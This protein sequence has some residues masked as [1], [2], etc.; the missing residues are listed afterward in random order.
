MIQEQLSKIYKTTINGKFR[1]DTGRYKYFVANGTLPDQMCQDLEKFGKKCSEKA[2][3]LTEEEATDFLNFVENGTSNGTFEKNGTSNGTFEKNGTSN[4]TFEK[5]GTSNGTLPTNNNMFTTPQ[6]HYNQKKGVDIYLVKFNDRVEKNVFDAHRER[7]KTYNGYYSTFVKAFVFDTVEDAQNF[8][9]TNEVNTDYQHQATSQTEP[10]NGI[11][12][13]QHLA[14]FTQKVRSTNSNPVTFSQKELL[15]MKGNFESE[16]ILTYLNK[17]GNLQDSFRCFYDQNDKNAYIFDIRFVKNL[18]WDKITLGY[19]PSMVKPSGKVEE[20]WNCSK[21]ELRQYKNKPIEFLEFLESNFKE[22]QISNILDVPVKNRANFYQ[23][24]SGKLQKNKILEDILLGKM[25][26]AEGTSFNS[27]EDYTEYISEK[28]AGFFVPKIAELNYVFFSSDSRIYQ[29]KND[30]IRFGNSA[31]QWYVRYRSPKGIKSRIDLLDLENA[32][33]GKKAVVDREQPLQQQAAIYIQRAEKLEKEAQKLN[34]ELST[35]KRDTPKRNKEWLSK[36][37]KAEINLDYAQIYRK[38]A[39]LMTSGQINDYLFLSKLFVGYKPQTTLIAYFVRQADYSG[40]YYDAS[41]AEKIGLYSFFDK[42][43]NKFSKNIVDEF[44]NFG[45]DEDQIEQAAQE[46]ISLNTLQPSQDNGKKALENKINALRFSKIDGFFP[47]PTPII[48]QMIALAKIE[49][50]DHILEPSAGM[51]DIADKVKEQ[52]P[53]VSIDVVEPQYSLREILKLKGYNLVADDIL[54]YTGKKYD[55]ILM[56][57]PF[58]SL[59]D[60]QHIQYCY[61][62]LLKDGGR[63][64]AIASESPFFRKD[65]AAQSL[66][67]LVE[68]VGYSEKLPSDAFSK[69]EAFRKTGVQT[70]LVLLEK[71]LQPVE[72]EKD[73]YKIVLEPIT[74]YGNKVWNTLMQNIDVNSYHLGICEIPNFKNEV[75]GLKDLKKNDFVHIVLN[76]E[77]FFHEQKGFVVS[78]TADKISIYRDIK[79]VEEIPIDRISNLEFWKAKEKI[80]VSYP[81]TNDA[82]KKETLQPETE[83]EAWQ[84]TLHEYFSHIQ[85][86]KTHMAYIAAVKK[87]LNKKYPLGSSNVNTQEYNDFS[88]ALALKHSPHLKAIRQALAEGKTVPKEVLAEYPDLVQKNAPKKEPLQ[89]KY[90]PI[91]KNEN[92]EFLKVWEQLPKPKTEY[93]LYFDDLGWSK[94]STEKNLEWHVQRFKVRKIVDTETEKTVWLADYQKYD[95]YQKY[96]YAQ[97]FEKKIRKLKAENFAFVPNKETFLARYKTLKKGKGIAWIGLAEQFYELKNDKL[98]FPEGK[99]IVTAVALDDSNDRYKIEIYDEDSEGDCVAS[100]NF[101]VTVLNELKELGNGEVGKAEY[102]ELAQKPEPT[103]EPLQ[104]EI[105][106]PTQ[107]NLSPKPLIYS[108]EDFV[109]SDILEVRPENNVLSI[110]LEGEKLAHY[111]V[112]ISDNKNEQ[113]IELQK[114]LDIVF[115]NYLQNN[116]WEKT[117]KYTLDDVNVFLKNLNDEFRKSQKENFKSFIERLKTMFP[118]NYELVLQV[119]KF[120]DRPVFSLEEHTFIKV[121]ALVVAYLENNLSPK[122]E[123]NM[124]NDNTESI[125]IDGNKYTR[126]NTIDGLKGKKESAYFSLSEFVPIQYQIVEADDLQPSHLGKTLNPMHTWLAKAQPRN[127][128]V[129]ESGHTVPKMIANSL[130]PT[131]ITTGTIA[132][133][134]SPVANSRGEVIQGNGRAYALKLYWNS[135]SDDPKGYRDF[136]I[137]NAGCFGF[138]AA[139]KNKI[140]GMDKPVLIRVADVDDNE[141]IRLGQFSTTDMEAVTSKSTQIKAKINRISDD[142][143][144]KIVRNLLSLSDTYPDETLTEIIRRSDILKFFVTEGVIRADELESFTKNGAISEE[145]ADFVRRFLLNSIFKNGHVSTSDAFLK[146]P[147]TFQKGFEKATLVILKIPQDKSIDQEVSDSILAYQNFIS[148]GSPIG[149]WRVQ[150][151]TFGKTP[152]DVFG[153]LPIQLVNEYDMAKTQKDIIFIF[154]KYLDKVADKPADMFAPA[155]KGKSKQ[156]ALLELYNIKGNLPKAKTEDNLSPAPVANKKQ[157]LESSLKTLERTLRKE[158]NNQVLLSAKKTLEREIKRLSA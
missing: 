68:E 8:A 128:S 55:V 127:R 78:K 42:R 148:S 135:Y 21:E 156:E 104:P 118:A 96:D 69:N 76:E 89:E 1:N 66:R 19:T 138:T 112:R 85:A 46:V 155:Q 65:K 87:E 13:A 83:K 72:S 154:K 58:E 3:N 115:E 5:N 17:Y 86:N 131:E 34:N 9:Q 130:R 10:H 81:K 150:Y 106:N 149:A 59:Q 152:I 141:A 15:E 50:N 39:D 33:V 45:I 107:D 44:K 31:N 90:P 120:F 47:T 73:K 53:T 95:P 48:E 132:Y 25:E 101:G 105:E 113:D 121:Q 145:G 139:Q 35:Q 124:K 98:T 20:L 7:A 88:A 22:I 137:E 91:R 143:K 158:P 80:T 142:S 16:H 2:V 64:V 23:D 125:E 67:D 77:R 100:S 75:V 14:I 122:T 147:H 38:I 24:F 111:Y 27:Y 134:G 18:H 40:G 70:R 79:D 114:T 151:D 36:N 6:K 26:I 92:L 12:F 126:Q 61:D 153:L 144:N 74:V 4:G 37:V 57:P 97:E 94:D 82:P 110:Y 99:V 119:V 136:L 93:S 123:K 108:F 54:E 28:N 71:P 56:N 32:I 140:S 146:L 51:G 52:Y 43:T 41:R 129:G 84:M 103:K 157:I 109:K 63:L 117:K 133:S 62:N 49:E 102:P 29:D 116:L 60:A 11:N 30:L